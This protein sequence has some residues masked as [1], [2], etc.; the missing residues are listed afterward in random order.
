[1]R[2]TI[3]SSNLTLR[4]GLF[5]W[6]AVLSVSVLLAACGGGG[7][8]SGS[9]SVSS[10]SGSNGSS[11]GSS[12]GG[13]SSGSPNL[14][15]IA[16]TASNTVPIT[17]GPGAQNFVNIPNVSVTVCAPGTS[18]CQVINN[19]QLDTGSYGLRLASD[20]ATQIL[21][22]LPVATST[23][24]GQ[25][26]ECTQFADGFTWGTVRT[27]DV[28]IGGE[29]ASAI[30]IQIVGDLPDST[31]PTNGCINGSNESTSR[32]LGANGILG[33]GVAATDCGVN[34]TNAGTSNYYSCPSGTNCSAIAVAVA[35]QVVNPVTKFAVD[36][37]GVI[38]QLPP[39]TMSAASVTGTL[40]FGIGTQSN[41]VQSAA[42]TSYRSTGFGDLAGNYKGSAV[43]T[44][45]DSGSNGLFFT[46]SSLPA[47]TSTFTDFY[48]PSG[49]QSLSATV[50]GFN[51]T[52]GTV[53]FTVLNAQTL[54]ASGTNYALNG[55]AGSIGSFPT[56]FDFGLPFFFG[57][58]VY[59]GFN[60]NGNA[61][62]IAF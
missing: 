45:V 19:I 34:C 35:Q 26:A 61:P 47:C 13:S 15:P 25:L 52:S 28:K 20:A 27:A 33:V 11:G 41:N 24:G 22:S 43:T 49:A 1:M 46:D 29:S 59:I 38:V 8:D 5:R 32:Q 55:L 56:L 23:S 42:A 3:F 7:G 10:G 58:Y 54:A 4:S 18:T 44:I 53:D 40:V 17:V 14:Q 12:G 51:G 30:P 16:S 39:V 50:T 2:P 36:N 57:R 62:Y 6:L 9:S 31:V 21:G 48:C 37:N 60:T